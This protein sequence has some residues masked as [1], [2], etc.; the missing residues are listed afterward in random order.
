MR[1]GVRQAAVKAEP[2]ADVGPW[3]QRGSQNEKKARCRAGN[4]PM[5]WA[6][7]EG[8]EPQ[9]SDAVDIYVGV[10]YLPI[11]PLTCC[12]LLTDAQ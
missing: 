1:P 8:L 6:R 12:A 5:S 11:C 9:P 3:L 7:L 2:A 10:S 4:G